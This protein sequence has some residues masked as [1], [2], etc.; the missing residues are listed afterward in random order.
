MALSRLPNATLIGFY[1][2]NGS[3]GMV[4]DGVLMPGGQQVGWPFGQSLDRKKRV[5][6]DSRDL[7]GGI[8][9]D[10]RVPITARTMGKTLRGHDVLLGKALRQLRG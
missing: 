2:T 5:Q 9:P 10:I 1:G 8:A 7:V 6:I 3:F 4:G